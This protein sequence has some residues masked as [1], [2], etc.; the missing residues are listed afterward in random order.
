MGSAKQ[1]PAFE[2]TVFVSHERE[3]GDGGAKTEQKEDCAKTHRKYPALLQSR[4]FA[5]P[6]VTHLQHPMFEGR[7]HGG[8]TDSANESSVGSRIIAGAHRY[9]S[10]D[11]SQVIC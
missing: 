9:S 4:S 8:A 10:C 6:I 2:G 1:L 11:L 7:H 5:S 3:C